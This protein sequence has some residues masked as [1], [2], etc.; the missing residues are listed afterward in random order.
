M[1]AINDPSVI[2]HLLRDEQ[3]WA[4]VGLSNNQARDAFRIAQLLLSKGKQIIPVHPAGA[5]VHGVQGYSSLAAAHAVRGQI[6][7][8]DVFVNSELAGQVADEAIA[9]GAKAVWFQLGVRDTAAAERVLDAGMDMVMDR[10]PAI[11]WPRIDV[12]D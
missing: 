10:C 6:D 4:V 2:A 9:M 7:V 8:V 11:E 3:V 12:N 5:S 1:S